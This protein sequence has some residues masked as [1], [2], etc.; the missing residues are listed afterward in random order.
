MTWSFGHV[1]EIVNA[2]L[3]LIDRFPDYLTPRVRL[4]RFI[5]LR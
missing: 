4:E 2:L 5:A 3:A 1:G